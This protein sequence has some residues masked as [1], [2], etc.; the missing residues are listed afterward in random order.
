[1]AIIIKLEA[2]IFLG[3]RNLITGPRAD[4]LLGLF[5]N[6]PGLLQIKYRTSFED[7]SSTNRGHLNRIYYELSRSNDPLN[8]EY[9]FH[10]E[11]S[12]TEF[13]TINCPRERIPM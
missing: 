1:M 5:I 3:A 9:G 13:A 11:T 7:E 6:I 12:Y 10:T 8:R 2:T 4:S